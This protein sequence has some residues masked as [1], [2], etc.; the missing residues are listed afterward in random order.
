MS[1]VTGLLIVLAILLALFLSACARIE[2]LY[3][4]LATAQEA[5]H[6]ECTALM[7][8]YVGTAHAA[9]VLRAAAAEIDSPRGRHQLEMLS[10]TATVGG[11]NTPSRW[12]VDRAVD[13]G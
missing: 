13:G 2:R 9:L 10:R 1:T 5:R 7:A 11:P 12:L 8:D 4:A 6:D 3:K